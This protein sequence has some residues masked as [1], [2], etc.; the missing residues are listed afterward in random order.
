[1]VEDE[2]EQGQGAE[3][4]EGKDRPCPKSQPSLSFPRLSMKGR[5][6]HKIAGKGRE[7]QKKVVPC[8]SN[9]S[10]M[11]LPLPASPDRDK[12]MNSK[13]GDDE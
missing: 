6:A 13:R 4:M 12:G 3:R 5:T 8:H 1:M 2:E 10:G 7:S 11:G 9:D